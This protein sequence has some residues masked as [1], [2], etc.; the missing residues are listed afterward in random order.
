MNNLHLRRRWMWFAALAAP[1]AAFLAAMVFGDPRTALLARTTLTLAAS[2]VACAVPLGTALAWL[3]FRTNLPLRRTMAAGLSLL[4]FLPLYV[5]MGAWQAGFG[6]SGWLRTWWGGPVL[7]DGWLGAVIVHTAAAVPWVA[8]I[9]GVGMR[10]IEPELEESALLDTGPWRVLWHVT[11]PGARGAIG[12]A[13]LWVAVSV[14]GEMTVTDLFRVRTLAEELYTEY[15]V[16]PGVLPLRLLPMMAIT[17]GL[18]VA[19]LALAAGLMPTERP[20]SFRRSAVMRLQASRG[21][22]F[23]AAALLTS[24]LVLTPIASLVQ[25]AGESFVPDSKGQVQRQWSLAVCLARV[26]AIPTDERYYQDIRWSLELVTLAACCALILA[27]PP[28]WLARRGGWRAWPAWMLAALLWAIPGPLLGHGLVLLLNQPD[29]PLL[30]RLYDDRRFAPVAALTMKALPLTLLIVWH[31]LRGIP[32]EM[33]EAA[34]L[35]GAGPLARLFRVALPQR[36][37][38]LAS[39]WLAGWAVAFADLGAVLIVLPPGVDMVAPQ[40]FRLLHDGRKQDMAALCLAL[41]PLF[42]LIALLLRQLTRRRGPTA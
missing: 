20:G 17:A 1:L 11:L 27:V 39:G 41:L 42:A 8:A 7:V 24:L 34:E 33:L 18:I 31:G 21:P 2:V 14:T 28:A 10:L 13:A 15:A 38:L 19:G 26:N 29:W 5:Q 30:S 23:M 6:G 36:W 25:A 9:V 35:D 4:L 12:V 16:E 3:L 22:C 40:V 37:T 32:R